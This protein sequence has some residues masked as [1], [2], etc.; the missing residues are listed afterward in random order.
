MIS[1][2][3]AAN[4]AARRSRERQRRRNERIAQGQRV[5]NTPESVE[6]D[7]S[8]LASMFPGYDDEVLFMMLQQNQ[9][10]IAPT[11]EMLLTMGPGD[12]SNSTGPA[13]ESE[14]VVSEEEV[15]PIE[16]VPQVVSESEYATQL[17]MEEAISA[18]QTGATSQPAQEHPP[19]HRSAHAAGEA[20]HGES[21]LHHCLTDEELAFMLENDTLFQ[22]EL[23]AY[24]GE[25]FMLRDFLE[26][27]NYAESVYVDDSG[28][29]RLGTS[30]PGSRI[31]SGTNSGQRSSSGDLG[32]VQGLSDFGVEMRKQIN[33]FTL[34]YLSNQ[35]SSRGV[36]PGS[37]VSG[38]T[39]SVD[40]LGRRDMR[41]WGGGIPSTSV[42][43]TATEAET[44][45][46]AV[47]LVNLPSDPH[48]PSGAS[49][50]ISSPTGETSAFLGG[51]GG[52]SAGS[53]GYGGAG[54]SADEA[55]DDD[56]M[57]TINLLGSP[58][59]DRDSVQRRDSQASGTLSSMWSS[60]VGGPSASR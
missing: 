12:E 41:N 22:Q 53:R 59:P 21:D 42:V 6:S 25:D 60:L 43:E 5:V 49:A 54:L 40:A 36:E 18:Q 16:C 57:E 24:F 14:E 45:S 13:P 39:D 10:D 46:N 33:S 26:S 23:A 31:E 47:E 4:A 35:G 15:S 29:G 11:I 56:D 38:G 1:S 27:S 7:I 34:K 37:S 3:A 20:A 30:G 58:E 28:R 44:G 19:A 17:A 52:H 50:P 2:A 32:V 51:E 8:T 48:T 55:D 9:Y